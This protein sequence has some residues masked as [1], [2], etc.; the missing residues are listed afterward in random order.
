MGQQASLVPMIV[1][2][3]QIEIRPRRKLH[4]ADGDAA[5]GTEFRAIGN[6][7]TRDY[8]VRCTAQPVTTNFSVPNGPTLQRLGYAYSD[9]VLELDLD[10]SERDMVGT[11]RTQCGSATTTRSERARNVVSGEL[12]DHIVKQVKKNVP[13]AAAEALLRLQAPDACGQTS[14]S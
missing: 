8:W 6:T 5:A 9:R 4:G 10:T 14:A 7:A 12:C 3:A 11:A 1:L 2:C 13:G